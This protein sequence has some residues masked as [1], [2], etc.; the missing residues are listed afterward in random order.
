VFSWEALGAA[1]L[2][3][4]VSPTSRG[5]SDLLIRRHRCLEK[6]SRNEIDG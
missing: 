5:G 3:A 2:L 6:F 4:T 1:L